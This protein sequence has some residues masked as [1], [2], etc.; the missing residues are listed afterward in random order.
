MIYE[1][2]KWFTFINWKPT[3]EELRQ[4]IDFFSVDRRKVREHFKNLSWSA[5]RTDQEASIEFLA[6]NLLPGEYVHLIFPDDYSNNRNPFEE[7]LWYRNAGEKEYWENA[8]RI[9]IKIGWPKIESIVVPLFMWL[10]DPNWP[11]SELIYNYLMTIPSDVLL[12]K[13]RQV[14]NNQSKYQ[15]YDY[16]DLLV[17]FSDMREGM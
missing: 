4:A 3:R 14:E 10:L 11:G 16:A 2:K 15:K 9:I 1:I 7:D 12:D 13:M 5:D 8:A 6:N 17:I